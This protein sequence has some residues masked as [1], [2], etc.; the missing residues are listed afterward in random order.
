MILNLMDIV[1]VNLL[2][3]ASFFNLKH[4]YDY[5]CDRDRDLGVFRS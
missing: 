2:I 3:S 1:L 5:D 4:D